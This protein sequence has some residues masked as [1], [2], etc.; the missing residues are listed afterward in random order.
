[1]QSTAWNVTGGG[2]GYRLSRTYSSPQATVEVVCM[3]QNSPEV[4]FVVPALSFYFK[5]LHL[6]QECSLVLGLFTDEPKGALVEV[7]AI[8][9]PEESRS[10]MLDVAMHLHPEDVPKILRALSSR[11][12]LHFVI[13]NPAPPDEKPFLSNCLVQLVLPNDG[14]FK[15]PYDNAVES[16][17]VSQDATR[18][19]QLGEGWYRRRSPGVDAQEP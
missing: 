17:L 3:V 7:T 5:P 9:A 18:A 6:K 14:A 1:M 19:R 4:N 11:Q 16:V 15:I 2:H 10:T 13:A 12:D 8:P